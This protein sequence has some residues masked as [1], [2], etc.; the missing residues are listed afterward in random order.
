MAKTT[1]ILDKSLSRGKGEI[2]LSTFAV[3]FSEMVLYAQNRS[4]TVTD[5]HDKIASYG[6]QVGLR[7]FDIIVLREKGYK[8]ETKLLGMLMFIKSTVWKNLFGKEADKLER[9]NDDHCTYLLIEKDPLVN[10]YI[11]VPRDK[12]VL[13]CAAFAAGIVEAILESASFKCKVTAHWHNGT[14]YVIQFDESVIARENAL[15]DSN[16]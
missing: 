4:E 6:K 9:S 16:R 14:A 12:G 8:R 1:G 7:M 13:N 2:N 15:L 11:S 10:T 5:I 3:L